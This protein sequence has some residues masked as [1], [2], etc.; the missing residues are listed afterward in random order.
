MNAKTKAKTDLE[1][2]SAL[3]SIAGLTIKI[4][5]SYPDDRGFFRELIRQTDPF[6]NPGFGQW[7]HSKMQQNTVKAWH[8]HHKQVDWWYIGDGVT[9]CAFYDN[10]KQSPTYKNLINLKVGDSDLDSEAITA[11]IRI[12]QGVL[13][14]LKVLSNTASIF[15]ITS[16]IYNPEDEGRIPFNSPEIPFCWGEESELIISNK[17]RVTFIPTLK[18]ATSW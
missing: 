18:L 2:T 3:N 10:R 4:L 17:D 15:Y 9:N 13:H 11:V 8:F 7:S 6:F 1:K 14:G 12:P 16:E 5:T